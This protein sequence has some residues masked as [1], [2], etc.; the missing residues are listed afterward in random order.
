MW[1]SPWHIHE[2]EDQS[3]SAESTLSSLIDQLWFD[4]HDERSQA[5]IS[6]LELSP[7]KTPNEIAQIIYHSKREST[8]EI[9][10]WIGYCMDHS[11]DISIDWIEAVCIEMMKHYSQ[12]VAIILHG[13][14]SERVEDKKSALADIRGRMKE[15]VYVL[16]QKKN[17]EVKNYGYLMTLKLLDVFEEDISR[18]QAFYNMCPPLVQL[19]VDVLEIL[20]DGYERSNDYPRAYEIYHTLQV[21]TGEACYLWSQISLLYKMGRVDEARSLYAFGSSAGIHGNILFPEFF[22]RWTIERDRELREI[23]KIFLPLYKGDRIDDMTKK[24]MIVASEYVRKRLSVLEEIFSKAEKKNNDIYDTNFVRLW[25]EKLFLLEVAVWMLGYTGP[26]GPFP[27]WVGMEYILTLRDLYWEHQEV[28]NPSILDHYFSLH[29][30]EWMDKVRDLQGDNT[31]DL[32]QNDQE[33]GWNDDRNFVAGNES[34]DPKDFFVTQRLDNILDFL[35][36]RVENDQGDNQ[37]LLDEIIEF[38]SELSEHSKD[39]PAIDISDVRF[40]GDLVRKSLS[41]LSVSDRQQYNSLVEYTREHYW[42]SIL[43]FL[44]FLS[45]NTSHSDEMSLQGIQK[46]PRLLLLSIVITLL[47]VENPPLP[48]IR[49]FITNPIFEALWEGETI[50]LCRMLYR[51]GLFR[52]VCLFLL[53]DREAFGYAE[54]VEIFFQ[55]LSFLDR[56]TQEQF[57]DWALDTIDE[58]FDYRDFSDFLE[59]MQVDLPETEPHVLHAKMILATMTDDETSLERETPSYSL[60][61]KLT[62]HQASMRFTTLRCM[63]VWE[64]DREKWTRAL[65][66]IYPLLDIDKKQALEAILTWLFYLGWKDEIER[67]VALWQ[68]DGLSIGYWKYAY[69]LLWDQEQQKEWIDSIVHDPFLHIIP[70]PFIWWIDNNFPHELDQPIHG[71]HTIVQKFQLSYIRAYSWFRWRDKLERIASHFHSL[72]SYIALYMNGNPRLDASSVEAILDLFDAVDYDIGKVSDGKNPFSEDR[73]APLEKLADILVRHIWEFRRYLSLSWD[74]EV[75]G[76]IMSSEARNYCLQFINSL[77]SIVSW[78]DP[79]SLEYLRLSVILW[80]LRTTWWLPSH[81]WGQNDGLCDDWRGWI[82]QGFS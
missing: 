35:L 51:A 72:N 20:A 54:C 44:F 37:E 59:D 39:I 34:N 1:K 11:L 56:V 12:S 62:P 23:Y 73:V 17:E 82:P 66:D 53:E 2:A 50:F 41:T 18:I 19:S 58:L 6:I 48:R 14:D 13:G 27:E 64:W 3:D 43:Q 63:E 36:D 52:E 71:K 21:R 15:L 40:A 79:S 8:L 10:G 80:Q 30:Q 42:P 67:F 16:T 77:E 68:K 55:S 22:Y 28:P 24:F 61:T 60:A 47:S 5:A 81:S 25:V 78:F 45:A 38:Q 69:L 26:F 57:Y 76:D 65:M 7:G 75:D 49:E 32:T 74:E 33:E 46:D 70:E 9:F 29:S 31:Q 4:N